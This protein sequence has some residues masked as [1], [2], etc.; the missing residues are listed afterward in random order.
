MVELVVEYRK[1]EFMDFQ[2]RLQQLQETQ[3]T[4]K[5]PS[6]PSAKPLPVKQLYVR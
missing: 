5:E 2:Q 1:A 4:T 6:S 3:A